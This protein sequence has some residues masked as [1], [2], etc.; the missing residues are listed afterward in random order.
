[1]NALPRKD[2]GEERDEPLASEDEIEHEDDSVD[3]EMWK[4]KF[5]DWEKAEV[6]RRAEEE[7]R[8]VGDGETETRVRGEDETVSGGAEETV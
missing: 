4:Q 3:V 7:R 6:I 1:M 8:R 5:V 2:L